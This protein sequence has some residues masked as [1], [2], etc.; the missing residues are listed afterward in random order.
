MH[1]IIVF[2]MSLACFGSGVARAD[3]P[4]S[5]RSRSQ[6]ECAAL[7]IALDKDSDG[8]ISRLEASA[9]P[10]IAGVFNSLPLDD[11]GALSIVDFMEACQKTPLPA[12]GPAA[13][14]GPRQS[15][16]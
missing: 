7:F 13:K 14:T 2:T 4:A 11:S 5:D 12:P 8:R 1:R 9:D 15:H 10:V 16:P 3:P 6:P